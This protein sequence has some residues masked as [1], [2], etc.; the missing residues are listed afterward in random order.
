MIGCI[1]LRWKTRYHASTLVEALCC[2][3]KDDIG[4]C[5]ITIVWDDRFREYVLCSMSKLDELELKSEKVEF[6]LRQDQVQ[7]L[8]E[9]V[10]RL[11]LIVCYL[12]YKLS[13]WIQLQ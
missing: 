12:G 6:E 1:H 7:V 3:K 2:S 10:R 11:G 5:S 13:W 8:E 9:K 4:L